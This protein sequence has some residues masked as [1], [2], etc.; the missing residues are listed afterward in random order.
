MIDFSNKK[1]QYAVLAALSGCI[2]LFLLL[3]FVVLPALD[4]WK[5]DSAKTRELAKKLSEMRQVVQSGTQVRK[6]I[7]DARAVIK[8]LGADIPL[9]VLGNYL[10]GM[11]KYVRDCALAAGVGIVGI[12]DNDV[13]AISPDSKFKI[14]R[15]RVQVRCGY[16]DLVRLIS[17]VQAGNP[18][19]SVSGLNIVP[20]DSSPAV[21]E[22][23]FVVGWLVW[24]DPARRPAFLT[25]AAGI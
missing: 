14:Y 17:A 18:L 21:H 5:A 8:T 9:P 6:Q 10:L 7:E 15:V 2:A 13:L 20:R 12:A 22:V 1:V 11:D 4:A 16:D 3:Y 25:E 24:T 23:S 19:V